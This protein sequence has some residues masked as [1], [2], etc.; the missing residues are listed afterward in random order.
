MREN[1]EMLIRLKLKQ[2]VTDDDNDMGNLKQQNRE[3]YVNTVAKTTQLQTI[4]Q[5]H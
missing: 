3:D 1:E 4:Q 2:N 5:V